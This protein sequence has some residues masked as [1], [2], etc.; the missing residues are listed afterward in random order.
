MNILNLPKDV[1]ALLALELNYPDIIRLCLTNSRFNQ[2]VCQSD[3]FWR[4]KAIKEYPKC[5]EMLKDQNKKPRTIYFE[6]ILSKLKEGL[7]FKGTIQELYNSKELS[8]KN[9][10]ISEIPKEIGNLTNLHDL[11]LRNNNISEIPK[12]LKHLPVKI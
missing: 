10:N 1:L 8:L 4:N 11:Y 9:N 12:E 3:S 5:W 6:C 7:N 2:I